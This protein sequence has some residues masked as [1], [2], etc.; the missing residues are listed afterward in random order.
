MKNSA[1][2]KIHVNKVVP[3]S[4]YAYGLEI[5]FRNP[6]GIP[7]KGSGYACALP[8]NCLTPGQCRSG[9]KRPMR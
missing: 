5:L 8:A 9:N 2:M 1:S 7:D 6:A 4:L 3:I